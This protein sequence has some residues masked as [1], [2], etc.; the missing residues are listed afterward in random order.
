MT[1]AR[2]TTQSKDANDAESLPCLLNTRIGNDRFHLKRRLGSGG[3]SVVYLATDLS[4][5]RRRQVAVKCL[6]HKSSEQRRQNM[7]EVNLHKRAARLPGVVDIYD[8][9]EENGL[10]FLILQ[11]CDGGDL[12]SLV[13]EDRLFAGRDD[14]IRNAFGQL[15]ETVRGLHSMGIYHRD[16]KPENVLS[17][18][19]GTRLFI[20]DFGLAT[21]HRTSRSFGAGSHF[22]M[23][24]GKRCLG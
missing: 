16:L 11:Y 24:P 18:N 17:T 9:V 14:L 19:K 13:T 4:S 7:L 8:T 21:K 6:A 20:S 3:F 12:F 5:P 15:L 22:Y 2:Q 10:L 23:T 1:A